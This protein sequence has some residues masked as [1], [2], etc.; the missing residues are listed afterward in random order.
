MGGMVSYDLNEDKKNNQQNSDETTYIDSD[1]KLVKKK[2]FSRK[3]HF[4]CHAGVIDQ[5]LGFKDPSWNERGYGDTD[6]TNRK[7]MR[8]KF[9]EINLSTFDEPRKTPLEEKYSSIA[10]SD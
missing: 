2:F 10:I 8:K 7:F 4:R 9:E 1:R 6:K 5:G 3:E